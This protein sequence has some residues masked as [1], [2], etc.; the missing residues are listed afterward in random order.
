ML[1]TGSR[2]D[3]RVALGIESD[4]A[5]VRPV[6]CVARPS[7]RVSLLGLEVQ[8]VSRRQDGLVLP[9]MALRRADVADAAVA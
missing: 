4:H 1:S 2:A 6:A 8:R 9:V 7:R 5:D 3:H